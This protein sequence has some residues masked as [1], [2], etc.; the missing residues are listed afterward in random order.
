MDPRSAS[1]TD[2]VFPRHRINAR[3]I[4]LTNPNLKFAPQ[5]SKNS[6]SQGSS[7]AHSIFALDPNPKLW[8]TIHDAEDMDDYLHQ[9]YS[10]KDAD[11]RGGIASKGFPTRALL[12]VGLL[13]LMTLSLVMLFLGYPV[14]SY[15]YKSYVTQPAVGSN[16]GGING[17]GQVAMLTSMRNGLIDLETPKSEYTRLSQDGTTELQLVFSDEFN[18]D[19]RSFYPEDD[20]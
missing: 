19:G 2:S 14:M 9:S 5:S 7:K 8:P 15:I 1:V 18:E 4:S 6:N 3:S 10:I 17:T 12:N 13:G 11:K 20:P 16:P